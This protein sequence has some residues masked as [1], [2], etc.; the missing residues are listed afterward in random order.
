MP[1]QPVPPRKLP[2]NLTPAKCW[3]AS[4]GRKTWCL[5]DG[6]QPPHGR[7][8]SRMRGQHHYPHRRCQVITNSIAK[9]PKPSLRPM[10]GHSG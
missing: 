6:L 9:F 2:E 1:E 3:M 4:N 10:S 8:A 5:D 7:P